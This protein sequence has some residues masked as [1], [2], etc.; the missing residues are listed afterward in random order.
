[1]GSVRGGGTGSGAVYAVWKVTYRRRLMSPALPIRRSQPHR[2]ALIPQTSSMKMAEASGSRS[3][4]DVENKASS[5]GI[6]R[7]FG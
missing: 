1:M 3:K 5:F 4:A 6:N 2:H 7:D